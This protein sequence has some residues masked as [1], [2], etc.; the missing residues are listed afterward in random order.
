[1]HR[2]LIGRHSDKGNTTATL[3]AFQTHRSLQSGRYIL[4]DF[5]SHAMASDGMV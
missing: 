4:N 1:M 5:N 3:S 2:T